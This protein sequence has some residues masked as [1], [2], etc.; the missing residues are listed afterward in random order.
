MHNTS[1]FLY[2]TLGGT[3]MIR[4]QSAQIFSDVVHNF[5]SGSAGTPAI[6]GNSGATQTTGLYWTTTPTLNVAVS[7]SQAVGFESGGLK[8]YGSTAGNNAL[9]QASLLQY[10]EDNTT[11]MQFSFSPGGQTTAAGN[12]RFIRIGNK[13]TMQIPNYTAITNNSGGSR[14]YISTTTIPLR[15]QPP[16]LMMYPIVAV[17]NGGNVSINLYISSGTIYIENLT[18]LFANNDALSIYGMTLTW[19]I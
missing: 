2:L 15:F 17:L 19:I 13:I 9:Y 10:Y 8:L 4:C 18:Q 5:T 6:R 14:A 11:S 1:G 7:G 3:N 16:Y 12:V